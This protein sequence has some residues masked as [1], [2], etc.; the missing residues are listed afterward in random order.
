MSTRSI[1]PEGVLGREA[2]YTPTKR[3]RVTIDECTPRETHGR[4]FMRKI[5]DTLTLGECIPGPEGSRL[6]LVLRATSCGFK[7]DLRT[8]GTRRKYDD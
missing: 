5:G 3:T 6:P 2:V 7:T 1:R 4:G 8:I